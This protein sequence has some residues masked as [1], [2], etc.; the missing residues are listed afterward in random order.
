MNENIMIVTLNYILLNVKKY[1]YEIF[2][3][4]VLITLITT[5]LKV[6]VNT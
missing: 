4:M 1:I 5:Y 2:Q 6:K 3:I